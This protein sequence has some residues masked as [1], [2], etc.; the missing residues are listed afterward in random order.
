MAERRTPFLREEKDW[1]AQKRSSALLYC[2]GD[3]QG[4]HSGQCFRLA[5][6]NRKSLNTALPTQLGKSF[7]TN[8]SL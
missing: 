6:S 4:R 3:P 5:A 2:A 7:F 1:T 8:R